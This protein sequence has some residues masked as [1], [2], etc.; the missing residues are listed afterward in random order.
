MTVKYPQIQVKL[1]GSDSNAFAVLGSVQ[2]ALRKAG[3][4]KP[5]IDAFIAEA[6]SGDYDHLL[7]TC[8]KTVEVD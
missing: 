2:H 3:V 6:T 4:P 1:T 7:A 5:E 8:M